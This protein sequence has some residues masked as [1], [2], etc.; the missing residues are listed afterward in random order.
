[1]AQYAPE[2]AKLAEYEEMYKQL[3][4]NYGEEAAKSYFDTSEGRAMLSEIE[5]SG[6][7]QRENIGNQVNLAGGSIEQM[8]AANEG[9]NQ[10]VAGA[11]TG[12]AG[13]A[14][15]RRMAYNN[16]KLGTLGAAKGTA[17]D[18]INLKS[19][20][21]SN[22]RN[23]AGQVFG[24]ASNYASGIVNNQVQGISQ[25]FGAF[26]DALLGFGQLGGFDK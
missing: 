18:A 26:G 12:L 20:I 16:L 5:R 24:N 23:Y 6:Q 9:V 13:R 15:S 14:E 21:T 25:G 11:T 8:L 10:A 19:G 7:N 17:S 3:A 2:F 22:A 4:A 1:M